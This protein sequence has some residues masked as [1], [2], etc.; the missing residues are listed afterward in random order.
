MTSENNK[1]G[2]K[3]HNLLHNFPHKSSTSPIPVTRLDSL[4]KIKQEILL[5]VSRSP[6]INASEIVDELSSSL[7]GRSRRNIFDHIKKLKDW[8]FIEDINEKKPFQLQLSWVGSKVVQLGSARVKDSNF[9]R[10][11]KTFIEFTMV[12][13]FPDKLLDFRDNTILKGKWGKVHRVTHNNWLKV[14]VKSRFPF[15]RGGTLEFRFLAEDKPSKFRVY[16]TANEGWDAEDAQ[17]R[18]MSQAIHLTQRFH[19]EFFKNTLKLEDDLF[20][21]EGLNEKGSLPEFESPSPVD[22]GKRV[23]VQTEDDDLWVDE[24]KGFAEWGTRR[25]HQA[26]RLFTLPNQL[27]DIKGELVHLRAENYRLANDNL[28]LKQE[29]AKIREDNSAILAY[30]KKIT[31][32]E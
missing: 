6:T 23:R 22:P 29:L 28:F 21:W 32:E 1:V 8:R 30:L 16:L 15:F 11:E 12:E 9:V 3:P 20:S 2:K 31:M 25:V 5:L 26:T 10:M 7:K 18:A 17:Y 13:S 24:S 14:I 4:H 27:D 19:I